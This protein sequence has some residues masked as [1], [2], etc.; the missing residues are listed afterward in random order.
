MKISIAAVAL[1][2]LHVKKIL[3]GIAPIS[4]KGDPVGFTHVE[5]DESR[6]V[7]RGG[8][9]WVDRRAGNDEFLV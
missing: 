2:R 3:C 9:Y 1:G 6:T 7:G 5:E 4:G 8:Q